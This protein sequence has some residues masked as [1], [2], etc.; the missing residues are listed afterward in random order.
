MNLLDKFEDIVIQN[1]ERIDY[2]DKEICEELQQSWNGLIQYKEKLEVFLNNN[3]VNNIFYSN[4]VVYK[5]FQSLIH[6]KRKSFISKVIYHFKNKYKVNLPIDTITR[7]L[8]GKN[9]LHYEHILDLIF[10]ELGG[11]TFYERAV[12]EVKSRCRQILSRNSEV[13]V[14][15]NKLSISNLVYW[16]IWGNIYSVGY[17]DTSINNLFIGLS[18]FSC[19]NVEMLGR[20]KT[21]YKHL[22][23][24]YKKEIDIFSLQNIGE[25]KIDSIKFYKNG[26]VE[27]HFEDKSYAE[28][29]KKEYINYNF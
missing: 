28:Q 24:R 5:S 20:F 26:K 25:E 4:A 29:F 7:K 15:K 21:L 27:I 18:H 16:S 14:I 19:G 10:D 3:P 1:K 12:S 6:D 17:S 2:E 9:P 8:D 13:K 22:S 23:D 11:M